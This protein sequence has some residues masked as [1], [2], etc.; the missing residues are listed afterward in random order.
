MSLDTTKV[1]QCCKSSPVWIFVYSDG[2]VFAVCDED[3]KSP[4]YRLK[5][6]KIVN[7]KSKK[8]FTPEQLFGDKK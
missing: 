3:F 5:L 1:K 8:V 2:R 4:S 7:I 6:F